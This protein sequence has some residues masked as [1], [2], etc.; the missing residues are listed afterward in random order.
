[1]QS[2]FD[3]AN[4]TIL[5]DVKSERNAA[6]S[7]LEEIRV[8]HSQCSDIK[9]QLQAKTEQLKELEALLKTKEKECKTLV[10]FRNSVV[11]QQKN[12]YSKKSGLRVCFF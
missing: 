10:S 1:M 8:I 12:I 4:A 2:T 6:L 9:D 3:L 11:K 5:E 7:E